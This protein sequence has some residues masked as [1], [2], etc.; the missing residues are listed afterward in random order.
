MVLLSIPGIVAAKSGGGRITQGHPE[1]F[2]YV[3]DIRSTN[4][5]DIVTFEIKM[6]QKEGIKADWPNLD[7]INGCLTLQSAG[8]VIFNGNIQ[9]IIQDKSLS[10][11]FSI[12]KVI[13]KDARIV[14]GYSFGTSGPIQGG[15]YDIIELNDFEPGHEA[16]F[17]AVRADEKTREDYY[18]RVPNETYDKL[19]VTLAKQNPYVLD[20]ARAFPTSY[21]VSERNMDKCGPAPKVSTNGNVWE[22]FVFVTPLYGRYELRMFVPFCLTKDL[23]AVEFTEEPIFDII[24]VISITPTGHGEQVNIH[25]EPVFGE[26]GGNIVMRTARWERLKAAHFDWT[27]IGINL[28]TNSPVEGFQRI[29]PEHSKKIDDGDGKF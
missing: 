23:T 25:E 14:I 7:K 22:N 19:V 28:K 5:G 6:S 15:Y 1:S 10:F 12:S 11:T 29:L 17:A 21:Q 9:K 18:R 16:F 4:T 8:G 13:L 2:K 26:D 24:E 27:V 3:Y 20:F